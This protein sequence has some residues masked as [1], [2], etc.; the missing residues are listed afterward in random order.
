MSTESEPKI[1]RVVFV[2]DDDNAYHGITDILSE[3]RDA[4]SLDERFQG[5]AEIGWAEIRGRRVAVVVCRNESSIRGGSS[6]YLGV[7][8]S[9]KRGTFQQVPSIM[10]EVPF[11]RSPMK[12]SSMRAL[13]DQIHRAAL[14]GV[15]PRRSRAGEGFKLLL[16]EDPPFP[17]PFEPV[18]MVATGTL[19]DLEVQPE[20]VQSLAALIAHLVLDG[21]ARY[22]ERQLP[23]AHTTPVPPTIAHRPPAVTGLIGRVSLASVKSLPPFTWDLPAKRAGWHV[24]LGQNASGKS[25]LLRAI[26]AALL[27]AEELAALR[28]GWSRWVTI[29]AT[30]ATATLTVGDADAPLGWHISRGEITRDGHEF[31]GFSAAYGPFRRFTGGDSEF[32]REFKDRGRLL[33]HLSLFTERVALS[34]ALDWLKDLEFRNARGMPEGALVGDVQRFINETGL[35]PEGVRLERI[36]PDGVWFQDANGAVI[37]ADELSEGYRAVLSLALDLVR[38]LAVGRSREELF[39][40]TDGVL[41][42][43]PAMVVLVDEIDAHLHPTWQQRIGPWFA[44]RFPQAQFIVATHSAIV[45]QAANSVLLLPTPGSHEP[46]RALEGIELDRLRYGSLL[47]AYGTGVFGDGVTRSPTSR[48][49]LA[50]LAALNVAELERPLTSNERAEQEHLRAALPSSA[51]DEADPA[52]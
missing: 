27:S 49:M 9:I 1:E 39:T 45:C 17:D 3:R 30:E 21:F 29:G 20:R 26:A 41:T 51:F 22:L 52:S 33:R 38:H 50:R 8:L 6:A 5:V 24:V 42:V 19:G 15:G 48:T 18:L 35:L 36:D 4:E 47:D 12:A 34:A 10:L 44:A 43:R 37:P 28:E 11:F 25:S 2:V 31:D 23:S 7:S 14:L 40:E 13:V 16:P 46:P 32:L